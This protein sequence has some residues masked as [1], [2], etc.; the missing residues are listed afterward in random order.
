MDQDAR[1]QAQ[2]QWNT[3]PCGAVDDN[4]GSL[5]YF[6]KVEEER[7]K[8]QSWMHDY[9]DFA[10]FTDKKVLEVGIG[11]GTDLLQ[12]AKYGAH[13]HGIDITD[14]HLELTDRNFSLRNYP[15][16][17]K[18]CDATQIDYPSDTFDCV[19]SFG[20]LHHIPESQQV[21]DEFYRILKPGGRMY[22]SVYYKWSAFHLLKKL[23]YD[24]LRHQMLFSIGYRGLMSTIESGADGKNIKP[25]VRTYSRRELGQNLTRFKTHRMDIRQLSEDH[26]YPQFIG[27]WLRRY[28]QK[29]D[30]R[31]GWYLIC[32]CTTPTS[33]LR[34]D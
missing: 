31:L 28:I 8:D 33:T 20:V 34:T 23:L 5:E 17:L 24:G 10:H 9:F 15:V 4:M 26:I 6:N 18:K 29:L 11:H 12:F 14:K 21:I 22:I 25:Y 19:Y 7:Y 32:D 16:T 13:C 3:N 2:S 30:H 27:R 1:T